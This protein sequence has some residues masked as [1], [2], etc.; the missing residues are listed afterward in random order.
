MSYKVEVA[1]VDD[2]GKFSSNGLR[3]AT[4]QEAELSA[5]ELMSRWFAVKEYRIAESTDPVN[6][7][8]T[9]GQNIRIEG[10]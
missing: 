4:K 3:F 9:N 2:G 7:T 10:V 6:Y 8:F 5:G 1:T